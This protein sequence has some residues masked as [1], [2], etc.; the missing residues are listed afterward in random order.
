METTQQI[1]KYNLWATIVSIVIPIVVAILF[2]DQYIKGIDFSFL[3]PIYAT[4]N[5]ITA[6]V[7]VMAVVAIKAGNRKRHELLMKIALGISLLFLVMYVLYHISTPPTPFGG[8]GAIKTIYYILLISHIL[9]SVII[10]PFVLFTY[11]RAITNRIEL[12]RKLAKITFPL[13][14]Y[15]AITGVVVYLMIA[16]YYA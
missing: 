2:R 14:L 9:L 12:H 7:L 15:V 11:I 3:P 5:G 13:W 10:I 6:V 16:P 4:L 1:K 8:E